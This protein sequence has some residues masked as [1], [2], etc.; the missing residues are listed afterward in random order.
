MQRNPRVEHKGAFSPLR[1]LVS[2]AITPV[3]ATGGAVT[4]L[5]T[6]LVGIVVTTILDMAWTGR[7]HKN[8]KKGNFEFNSTTGISSQ[9]V[10]GVHFERE[11]VKRVSYLHWPW[12]F[13]QSKP[14]I[15]HSGSLQSLSH[16][17]SANLALH[18]LVVGHWPHG[19]PGDAA[20]GD[21]AH[22]H[23]HTD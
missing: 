22:T 7:A 21:I 19:S 4:A 14:S 2:E 16:D 13:R 10:Q 5:L 12:S 17:P 15:R 6:V 1:A 18:C 3:P 23:T 20:V 8:A 11:G 9:G